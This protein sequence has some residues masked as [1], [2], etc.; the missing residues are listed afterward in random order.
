MTIRRGLSTIGTVVVVGAVII[1][2]SWVA[3]SGGSGETESKSLAGELYEVVAGNFEITVPTSGELVSENKIEIFNKL[4]SNAVIIELVD[5]GSF[6]NEGDVLIKLNDESIIKE[7]RSAELNVTAAQNALD[8]AESALVI[9]EKRKDSELSTKQL[10]IDLAT[11]AL[12]AWG[13]GEVIAKRQ[14]LTLAVQTAEKDYHRLFKKHESSLRL[15]GERFLSK[16]EL[17]R[18]EIAL[19]NADAKLK[20]TK[21]EVV[22]YEN[23]THKQEE[24]KKNSD[25]KQAV[26]ELDRANVRLNSE[27]K[28]YQA[29]VSARKNQLESQVEDLEKRRGQLEMCV[30]KSP[31]SGMVVYASSMGGRRQ[32]G[33]PLKA[34]KKLFRNEHVLSIPDTTNM[35]ANVKINE[36]LSGLV[37]KGQRAIVTCDA[38]PDSVFE[39]EVLSVGIL[40]EGGGWRDP[41]RRDYTVEI[42][43]MNMG[44]IQL[45]PSMRCSA[46]VYVEDVRDVLFIPIQAVH[47]TGRV[48]WIWTRGGGGYSQTKVTLGKFSDLFAEITTGVALGDVV[49]LREPSP[50]QVVERLSFEE[51]E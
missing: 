46:E 20:G 44:D 12:Q 30:V 39:G 50:G 24:Q 32:E 8:N 11:L 35:V 41:N 37:T 49:L 7:I 16:D 21:L 40:A 25:F 10:A 1:I 3:L 23:Y 29:T 38:Y 42:K 19:L 2:V 34:G 28:N 9:A 33:E 26:D 15:Y 47:R 45:K 36:A 51:N 22:V 31:A 14:Q 43:I 48:V 27:S 4:E 18:D 13:E 17:D 6:V 5:E